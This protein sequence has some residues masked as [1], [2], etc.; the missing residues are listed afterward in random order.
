MGE[1]E[2]SNQRTRQLWLV[3]AEGPTGRH[4]VADVAVNA[5]LTSLSTYAVPDDLQ[6]TVRPG[7]VVRVP[8][9]RSGRAVEGLC[10]RV[11]QRP[12]E[13]TRRLILEASP[14]WPWL[15]ERLAELGLWVSD[16]Y[17]CSPWKTFTAVLPVALRKPRFNTVRHLRATGHRPSKDLTAK[18]AAL[19]A[20]IGDAEVRRDE[21]L[22]QAGVGLATLR[23]L[24]KAGVVECVVRRELAPDRGKPA[25]GAAQ[26]A[27]ACPEDR[28]ELTAGQQAACARIRVVLSDTP[29]FRVFLLFGV[30]GSGKTEVYVRMIREVLRRGRQAILLIPEIALATQVVDRLARRFDRVAVLHSQLAPRTRRQTL[31]AIAAG[32]VDVVIGT[33]TA[34]F[35]PCLRLGLIVVDEE[36]ESSFKNLAAPFYHARDVAIKR[37][38]LERVP[39]VLG[40]A[41]PALE[42]WHNARHRSHFELLRLPDRV[43]GA[44]LP[45]VRL[46]QGRGRQAA[47]INTILTPAL[48]DELE[49]TLAAGQQAILLHNRRGYA[50]YLRCSACGLMVSCQRC[51]GHLVYH[52]AERA[53]KCHRCGTR[54]AVLEN[55]L[56][57]TCRGRLERT[58]LA[59]QR[60]EEELC[61]RFPDARLLRLDS[62]TMRRREDYRAALQ[63]FEARSADILL[64]TQMVAKGLDFP[65]VR[66]VGVIE[67]DAALSLPD[68]RASERV[69]Q[70]LVQVVGRAGRREGDSLALV[71][72]AEQ[73]APAIRHALRLDYEGFATH[74]LP[75]RRRFF[76]PP[77]ARLARLICADARP[78]RAQEA[79]QRLAEQLRERAGRIHAGLR[80]EPAEPCVLPRLREMLRFQVLVRGPRGMAVQTLL[81]EAAGAK[82]LATGVQRFTVDVDPIDLL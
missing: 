56:D 10:L 63:R 67:A 26:P 82:L 12:W 57:D 49:R 30:P 58:G 71:Q 52:Q 32:G 3:P 60:L 34:V 80:V 9:G 79:A 43:P 53:L 75:L 65:G 77:F 51:G 66:L 5:P 42:T 55:C 68:F 31:H 74:E 36:Q 15:S 35:A 69:F 17:A 18:Q 44:R 2:K 72:T 46:V 22:R 62:D 61:E 24:R 48:R 47:Q 38:Q 41:T 59:I 13:H 28:F 14:G 20:V 45:R 64:G 8:H 1:S 11:T 76:Y 50:V 25:A 78:G 73:P 27:A 6:G 7:A 70:L 33:R 23:T 40:S 19:L 4:V 54:T 81:Q 37:G 21:A 39:V 16:Y 29:A